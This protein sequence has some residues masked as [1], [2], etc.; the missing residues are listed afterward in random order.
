M[1]KAAA[2]FLALTLLGAAGLACAHRAVS[3]SAEAVELRETVLAGDRSAAAGVEVNFP[4]KCAEH[5]YWD[6][7]L[8]V[9]AE[10]AVIAEFRYENRAETRRGQSMSYGADLKVRA[11]FGGR[12]EST[13]SEAG[14]LRAAVL[15]M[16]ERT[17]PGAENVER[18]YL[19]DYCEFMPM[20][21]DVYIPNTAAEYMSANM[22][23]GFSIEDLENELLEM[24]RIPVPEDWQVEI[25]V[26]KGR[27]G[28][29]KSYSV[30]PAQDGAPELEC[31]SAVTGG[32]LWLAVQADFGGDARFECAAADGL[33]F[34]PFEPD[35]GIAPLLEL[36]K[37]ERIERLEPDETG[38]RLLLLTSRDGRLYLSVYGAQTE[39]VRAR[40]I[41]SPNP[42][43]GVRKLYVGDGFIVVITGEGRFV[44]AEPAESGEYVPRLCGELHE[45]EDGFVSSMNRI[46][47]C[48]DG[49]RLV[50][51]AEVYTMNNPHAAECLNGFMLWIYDENGLASCARYDSSLCLTQDFEY[52]YP[53]DVELNG[54]LS[55]RLP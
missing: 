34:M 39:Q 29:I 32:G 10:N 28:G 41:M 27:E 54:G 35:G 52:I 16:A 3:A 22:S 11:G 40:E 25:A 14:G 31:M 9:G 49:E 15:E 5:L 6:T 18:V 42:E 7:T 8:S 12:G 50:M 51:A 23:V 37:G 17:A 1:R 44:L 38:E 30:Y 4:T 53:L 43:E 19:R 36:G 45:P 2:L 33:Y 48:W 20:R 21:A 13:L 46:K 24:F 55:L 47:M 26:L